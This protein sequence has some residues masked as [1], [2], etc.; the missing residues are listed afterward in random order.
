M[1]FFDPMVSFRRGAQSLE[2]NLAPFLNVQG[3]GDNLTC[4]VVPV[5]DI[6]VLWTIA[7]GFDCHILLVSVIC[8]G[9]K[10]VI[11][12][13]RILVNLDWIVQHLRDLAVPDGTGI[14]HLSLQ[15]HSAAVLRYKTDRDILCCRPQGF[16]LQLLLGCKYF[17]WAGWLWLRE[18]FEGGD[19]TNVGYSEF[20]RGILVPVNA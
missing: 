15:V 16:K 5:K 18:H 2:I 17:L 11:A 1:L 19:A 14:G 8:Y 3:N 20:Q 10:S 9:E 13:T 12:R 7:V 4:G 6:R